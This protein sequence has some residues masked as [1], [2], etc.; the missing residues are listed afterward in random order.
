MKRLLFVSVLLLC[1]A[2]GSAQVVKTMYAT[3]NLT[4]STAGAYSTGQVLGALDSVK[5]GGYNPGA[6]AT[7]LQSVTV[8]D[9]NAKAVN[10]DILFFTKKPTYGTYTMRSS[11]ALN[12]TDAL[13]YIGKVVVGTAGYDTYSGVSIDTE[14]PVGLVIPPISYDA[15]QNQSLLYMITVAKGS[16]TYTVTRGVFVKLGFVQQP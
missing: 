1:A 5:F 4:V 10:F 13:Y 2:V 11:M 14:S 12:G 16:G 6:K 7:I 15:N 9:T 8:V 3:V